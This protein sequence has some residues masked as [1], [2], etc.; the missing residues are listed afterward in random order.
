MG[1]L[2]NVIEAWSRKKNK[3]LMKFWA[4]FDILSLTV[5]INVALRKLICQKIGSERVE[6]TEKAHKRY[7]VV[8]AYTSLKKFGNS[9]KRV[10]KL[11]YYNRKLSWQL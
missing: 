11:I 4:T 3:M 2:Y 6:S 5:E 1:Y 10:I 9:G 8:S 7:V